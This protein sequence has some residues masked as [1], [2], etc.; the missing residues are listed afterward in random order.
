[1]P[2]ETITTAGA[3]IVLATWG[4]FGDLHPYLAVAL[5]LKARGHR[6]VLASAAVYREKIEQAGLEFAPIRP[7]LPDPRNTAVF[8]DVAQRIMESR[9]GPRNLIRDLL[10]PSLRDMYE[11]L[12]QA[13]EGADLLLSHSI[14]YAA[15]LVV[16]KRGL[17][18]LS[19]ALQPIIF[20][21]AYAPP[22]PPDAPA[23]AWL[24]HYLPRPL[25][26][27]LIA[28][29]KKRLRP[30]VAEVDAFREELG[31]LP[32]GH[33]IFDGQWSPYG[34]LALFSRSLGLP[35][36]DWPVNTVQTG[37]PFY[38]Q[39]QAGQ[40]GL[41][42]DLCAFLK[43]GEPPIVFTLGTSAVMTP[44]R[45]YEASAEAAARIGRRAVLLV[46]PNPQNVPASLPPGVAAFDY[47][48][49]SALFPHAAA[50]V[51]QGGVGTTGQSLRAGRPQLVV[52]FAHDQPDNA[53]RVKRLG[54]ARSVPRDRYDT[55]TAARE[56][57]ALLEDP[58]HAA[59]AAE[60]GRAVRE[61][62]GVANA[63]AA[64]EAA[65]G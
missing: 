59:R 38:D 62:D 17:R 52:P 23:I 6:L 32:G 27:T 53:D 47:A 65:L 13:T 36:P 26:Q 2:G 5:G 43:A 22:V 1:M 51:H 21:S 39:L 37:F 28:A 57:Q 35:Q 20:L 64:I 55:N 14:L 42:D 3:R 9:D 54:V 31:L 61:E 60:G 44:G 40:A 50:I 25:L 19:V 56:L 63:C 4:S 15:P 8:R 45:F 34:T 10:I 58:G 16:E 24:R 18:W 12:W 49:Y 30:W 7:A 48:P 41:A 29:G 33:P 46:G 11:D